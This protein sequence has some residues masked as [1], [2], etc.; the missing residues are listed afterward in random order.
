MVH[1]GIGVSKAGGRGGQKGGFR[2]EDE[3]EEGSWDPSMIKIGG[4]QGKPG[5]MLHNSAGGGVSLFEH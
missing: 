3:D 2:T 4:D 5:L 1:H